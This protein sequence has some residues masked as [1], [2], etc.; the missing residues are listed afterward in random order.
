VTRHAQAKNVELQLAQNNGGMLLT[1]S[2]NGRGF[3]PKNID[4]INQFGIQGMRERTE[5]LGGSLELDS[6]PEGGTTI[7]LVWRGS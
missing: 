2:D 6:R 1:I 3:D 7:R 5:M 4:L